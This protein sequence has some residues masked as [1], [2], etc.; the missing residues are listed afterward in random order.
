MK[1]ILLT[2]MAA[3][4]AFLGGF[5]V[6]QRELNERAKSDRVKETFWS[7]LRELWAIRRRCREIK[8]QQRQRNRS[9]PSNEFPAS[10]V[11]HDSRQS[12]NISA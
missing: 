3:G 8:L 2:L 9:M 4:V 12:S 1:R 5:V 6:V 7:R 10:L 11:R